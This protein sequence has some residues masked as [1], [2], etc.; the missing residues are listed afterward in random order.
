MLYGNHR[1]PQIIHLNSSEQSY[2]GQQQPIVNL[3]GV[4]SGTRARWIPRD[5]QL[6]SRR[7]SGLKENLIIFITNSIPADAHSHL[8]LVMEN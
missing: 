1:D 6:V 5:V 3:V 2:Y 4:D 8:K 7:S